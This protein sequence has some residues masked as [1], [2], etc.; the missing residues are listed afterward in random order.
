M[1]TDFYAQAALE[2]LTA[3]RGLAE[4]PAAWRFLAAVR[5][6]LLTE[7]MLI[8]AEADLRGVYPEREMVKKQCTNGGPVY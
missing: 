8:V 6:F 7:L 3:G 4:I 1:A 2:V 5:K